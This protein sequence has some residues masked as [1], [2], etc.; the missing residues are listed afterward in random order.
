V[1]IDFFFNGYFDRNKVGRREKNAI[2][3]L[4]GALFLFADK[5]K[6][7]K[8]DKGK[9]STLYE[10]I[11]NR[12]ENRNSLPLF[13]SEGSSQ[14]K[15]SNI[16]KNEYLSFCYDNLRAM[17]GSLDIYGHGL[18]PDVD[19]HIIEAIKDSDTENIT[20]YQYNLS[21]M[22][23]GQRAHLQTTLNTRLGSEV[24]IIDSSEH[25]LSNW[26]VFDF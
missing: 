8:I 15:L 17:T 6:V 22:S 4:H 10:A 23:E 12:I 2:F 20:Y 7:I 19:N 14:E 24:I 3:F 5:N 13:I 26:S 9:F 11:Q 1:I 25:H 18:N 16:K 21:E